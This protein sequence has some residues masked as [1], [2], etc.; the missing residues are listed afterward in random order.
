MGEIKMINVKNWS[1]YFY[2]D[3][4]NLNEFDGSNIK[5]DRKNFSDIDIYYLGY[6]HKKRITECNEMNSVNPFYLKIT[7]MKSQFKKDKS[8]NV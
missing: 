3:I 7:D 8:D 6:E 5:A 2:N 1:Y 4:P